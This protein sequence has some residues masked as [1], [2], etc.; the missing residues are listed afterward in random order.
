[1][2]KINTKTEMIKPVSRLQPILKEN[3]E[4]IAIFSKSIDTAKKNKL[5]E[6]RKSNPSNSNN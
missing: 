6:K 5:N 1:M 4:L 2:F 3:E